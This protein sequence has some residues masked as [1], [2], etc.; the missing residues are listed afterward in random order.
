MLGMDATDERYNLY[1]LIQDYAI[2][3]PEESDMAGLFLEFISNN[4]DC[5]LRS[6]LKGHIT[7]S[8]WII[9]EQNRA[10]LLHHRK[11]GIWVQPGGHSD[12]DCNTVAV[13]LRE[14]HEET[15]LDDLSLISMHI[16][17]LDIHTMPARGDEPEHQHYDVRFIL[18]TQTPESI[19]V[20]HEANDLRW[21]RLNELD[22]LNLGESVTRMARKMKLVLVY[23]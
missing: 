13:S 4:H 7:G 12:G 2:T 21:F 15:G 3:N 10:L 22:G 17:D 8:S 6:N 20:N 23:L 1:K 19:Q 11:L 5:F 9:D 14:A 18:K 16:Y